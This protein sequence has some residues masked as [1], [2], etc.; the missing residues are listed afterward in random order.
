VDQ[1]TRSER[2]GINIS[3]TLGTPMK[4]PQ[5]LFALAIVTSLAVLPFA[6][7]AQPSADPHPAVQAPTPEA[8]PKQPSIMPALPGHTP[9][10][11]IVLYRLGV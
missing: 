4:I 9:H 3:T 6:V 11:Y 2:R 10:G 7:S 8:G 1:G 5:K